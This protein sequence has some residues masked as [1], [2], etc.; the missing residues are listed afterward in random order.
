MLMDSEPSYLASHGELATLK[1]AI[2]SWYHQDA[3]LDFS[4][5]VEIWASMWAAS[6]SAGRRRLVS[7]LEQ[8]LSRSDAEVLSL[9]NGESHAIRFDD[10]LEAREFLD[11]MLASFEGQPNF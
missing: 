8:L 2:G 10:G 7:Q 3:Y 11:S 5:D 9:W 4:E 1:N 6:D